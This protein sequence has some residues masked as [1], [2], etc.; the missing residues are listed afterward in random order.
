MR[1]NANISA[2]IEFF[3]ILSGLWAVLVVFSSAVQRGSMRGDIETGLA[4]C[5]MRLYARVFHGLRVR[6]KENIPRGDS[7][8]P[9]IV[10][11]NHT[12]GVDPLLIQ[13]VMS[14]EIRWVM[15]EDMRLSWLEEFWEWGGVI[16]VDRQ[17]PS[18]RPV[19]TAL[20]H[21][22]AGGVL[23]LFPEAQ[24]E[25]PPRVLLPFHA[26]VGA[27]VR[28]TGARV[29]PVLVEGTPS[30]A[31]SAWASLFIPSRAVVR[32]L[33]VIDYEGT[34]RPPAEIAEDLRRRY[35]EWTGWPTAE[36]VPAYAPAQSP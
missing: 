27:F 25:R 18:A 14:F 19:R 13:S 7:G 4:L 11:S 32:V 6:G 2:V 8:G 9:L 35:E 26:G 3:L 15:A 28:Q 24:I 20:A 33:P 5:A 17:K 36:A 34:R 21:L 23:G 16:F 10:V 29:L 31:R 22:R 1:V 30:R 12:A